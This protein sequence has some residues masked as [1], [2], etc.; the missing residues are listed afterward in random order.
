[1]ARPVLGHV[2]QHVV[3][4]ADDVLVFSSPA[5]AERKLEHWQLREPHVFIGWDRRLW[6]ATVGRRRAVV[7]HRTSFLIDEAAFLRSLNECFDQRL[8]V[9]SQDTVDAALEALRQRRGYDD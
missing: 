6:V 5:A 9:E 3:C 7:L 4:F 2:D 8:D 1:M